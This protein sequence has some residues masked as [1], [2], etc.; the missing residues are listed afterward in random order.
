[1]RVSRGSSEIPCDSTC[2]TAEGGPPGAWL[3]MTGRC[4]DVPR[5]SGPWGLLVGPTT[6]CPTCACC[7]RAP[8]N[9][10]C[11]TVTGDRCSTEPCHYAAVSE[12]EPFERCWANFEGRWG[13]TRYV[14]FAGT[15]TLLCKL[16]DACYLCCSVR[17]IGC[18]AF[19]SFCA[20]VPRCAFVPC[21]TFVARCAFVPCNGYYDTTA[22]NNAP[23]RCY[24]Y[25]YDYVAYS[26]WPICH[27]CCEVL[28]SGT[29]C[30]YPARR[31]YCSSYIPPPSGVY[32]YPPPPAALIGFEIIRR[33]GC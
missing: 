29:D 22:C 24:D 32:L 10:D 25:D 31:C 5:G 1:M 8:C 14:P 33:N 18:C 9:V 13:S 27:S 7:T 21:C 2:T 11:G 6:C 23:W 3:G 30:C 16:S 19:V 12:V 26:C 28:Y 4:P 15:P 17:G 20:L